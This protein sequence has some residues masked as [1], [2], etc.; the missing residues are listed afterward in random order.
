MDSASTIRIRP[1]QLDDLDQV[2]AIDQLSFSLPWPARSYRFELLENPTSHCWVA[3]DRQ[4]NILGLTVIWLIMDEAHIATFAVHPL[5]RRMG[6]GRKLLRDA[7]QECI[8]MGAI[9]A[10]LEV[11]AGNLPAQELYRAY[12]FEVVGRRSKYYAD[13]HEDALIMTAGL[14]KT[15]G[16]GQ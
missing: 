4:G 11:R 7:L 5:S 1:M 12:G 13:N 10:T 16:A 6:I 9:T 8:R 15:P 2:V 14:L 3:E